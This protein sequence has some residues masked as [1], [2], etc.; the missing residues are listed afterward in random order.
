MMS[1]CSR[2]IRTYMHEHTNIISTSVQHLQGLVCV[3][4]RSCRWPADF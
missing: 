3:Q 2:F 4:L 1:I